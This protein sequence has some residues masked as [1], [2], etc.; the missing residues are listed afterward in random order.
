MNKLIIALTGCMITFSLSA[1][2]RV[3]PTSSLLIDGNV[4]K[5]I[6]YSLTD[7]ESLNAVDIRDVVLYN[8]K[9]EVKDTL[10]GMKGIPLK[11][12]LEPVAFDYTLPKDLN[13]F[14]FVFV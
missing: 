5:S 10:T 4:R 14:Y 9:G 13:E 6:S 1:Q 12:L 3:Q 8:H 7:L 11:T 2:N